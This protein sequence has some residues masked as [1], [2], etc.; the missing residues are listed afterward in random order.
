M[1]VI[2]GGTTLQGE[3]RQVDGLVKVKVDEYAAREHGPFTVEM[4]GAKVKVGD[5]VEFVLHFVHDGEGTWR[6]IGKDGRVVVS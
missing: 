6:P 5:R 1:Q 3:V 4:G 2:R